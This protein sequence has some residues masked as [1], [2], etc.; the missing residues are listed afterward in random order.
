MC[1]C[2]RRHPDSSTPCLYPYSADVARLNTERMVGHSEVSSQCPDCLSFGRRVLIAHGR[3]Q[4]T[5]QSTGQKSCRAQRKHGSGKR[6]TKSVRRW[7]PPKQYDGCERHDDAKEGGDHPNSGVHVRND[8]EK[9]GN[10]PDGRRA[11]RE[12]EPTSGCHASKLP[13]AFQIENRGPTRTPCR[14]LPC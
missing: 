1:P 12:C 13:H 5:I 6:L 2:R 8:I 4:V 10:R 9:K 3:A 11:A 14:R 7:N